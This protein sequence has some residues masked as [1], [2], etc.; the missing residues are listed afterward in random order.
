MVGFDL[1]SDLGVTENFDWTN[2]PESLYCLIPGNI[3]SDISKVRQVLTHLSTLYAGVFF[4]P[5]TLE[6]ADSI[7]YQARTNALR[8]ACSGIKNTLLL[9]N[10]AVIVDTI[11]ILGTTGWYGPEHSNPISDNNR[12]NDIQYLGQSIDK[13]Q[14]YPDISKI[15]I[16][17]NSVPKPE[18]YFGEED[19]AIYDQL[20][21]IACLP[22]DTMQKIHTWAFGS[23]N[24]EVDVIEHNIHF[25]SN[26]KGQKDPYWAKRIII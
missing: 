23:Y 17:S 25:V 19:S 8:T 2:K 3:S 6:Y 4:V 13:L 26:P 7:D 16:L 20:P 11:A 15:L 10:S 14:L 18:L 21:L 1:I 5:G 22:N 9:Y 24:K 12:K